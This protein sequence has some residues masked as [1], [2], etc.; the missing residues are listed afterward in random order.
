[1]HNTLKIALIPV[2]LL[3]I[4][5]GISLILLFAYQKEIMINNP[6]GPACINTKILIGSE[7]Y[8]V[9]EC[10]C[11]AV[12]YYEIN[13]KDIA[14]IAK[15]MGTYPMP[16][17]FDTLTTNYDIEQWGTQTVIVEDLDTVGDSIGAYKK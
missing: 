12:I 4:V 2:F 16:S 17:V 3:I 6:I 9:K 5:T 13:I 10:H 14:D 11:N 7:W 8:A 15:R 1:M